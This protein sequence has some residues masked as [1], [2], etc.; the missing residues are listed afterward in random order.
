MRS[1]GCQRRASASFT[2]PSVR[3]GPRC[4]GGRHR[5]TRQAVRYGLFSAPIDVAYRPEGPP[6]RPCLCP[7]PNPPPAFGSAPARKLLSYPIPTLAVTSSRGWGHRSLLARTPTPPR[8]APSQP[9]REG[10]GRGAGGPL[11]VASSLPLLGGHAL[12]AD[13]FVRAPRS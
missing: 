3:V 6:S 2:C 12:D 4:R 10:K 7:S 8:G 1:Q 9:S 5:C 13:A 11:A